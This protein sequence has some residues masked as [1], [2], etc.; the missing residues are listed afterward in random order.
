MVPEKLPS[1]KQ[2]T[3]I[4]EK[5]FTIFKEGDKSTEMYF[6]TKGRI[7]IFQKIDIAKE[8]KEN[9]LVLATLGAGDFFGEMSTF[10]GKSRTASAQ[11]LVDTECLVM[12]QN[13]VNSIIQQRPDVGIKIIKVLCD[14]VDKSNENVERLI[15]V[16]SIERVINYFVNMST[17]YGQKPFQEARL[18]YDQILRIL[19]DKVNIDRNV[20]IKALFFLDKH[21]FIEIYEIRDVKY[22]RIDQKIIEREKFNELV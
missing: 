19:S 21:K 5:G 1:N 8:G 18:Q 17:G 7:E 2:N 11:A 4:F 10:R 6:I 15:T 22:I 16:N 20:L 3:L 13:T 9:K 14:R 12:S